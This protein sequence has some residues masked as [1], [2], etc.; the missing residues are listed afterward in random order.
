MPKIVPDYKA[1]YRYFPDLSHAGMLYYQKRTG[2]GRKFQ[3]TSS[4]LLWF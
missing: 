3:R 2:A 4:L 1:S